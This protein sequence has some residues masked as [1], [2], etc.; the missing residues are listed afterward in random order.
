MTL[1]YKQDG[2]RLTT[3]ELFYIYINNITEYSHK[4]RRGRARFANWGS[5]YTTVESI[6]EKYKVDDKKWKLSREYP[7]IIDTRALDFFIEKKQLADFNFSC[8]LVNYTLSC[9]VTTTDE[10]R[11]IDGSDGNDANISSSSGIIGS[12]RR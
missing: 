6:M 12:G 11:D 1:T 9:V 7:Q 3:T 10:R 2:W 8:P 5:N 4:R